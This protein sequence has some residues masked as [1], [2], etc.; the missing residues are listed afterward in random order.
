LLLPVNWHFPLTVDETGIWAS[1]LP[2]Q[3]IAAVT[4]FLI[5]FSFEHRFPRRRAGQAAALTWLLLMVHTLIFSIFRADLRPGRQ[6]LSW[7]IWAA[8]L[9]LTM[10]LIWFLIV[11]YPQRNSVKPIAME[12]GDD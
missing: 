10:A 6:G 4:L 3:W 1:R 11:F 12:K 8:I 2:L 5:Y 9:F 7:D